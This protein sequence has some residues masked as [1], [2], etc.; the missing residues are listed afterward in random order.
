MALEAKLVEVGSE[1][2]EFGI[3][4]NELYLPGPHP[5]NQYLYGSMLDVKY[6]ED[7][8]LEKRLVDIQTRAPIA[9]GQCTEFLISAPWKHC[10]EL[11]IK[12][13]T[14]RKRKIAKDF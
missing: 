7:G 5:V 2:E 10:C 12:R 9:K 11:S 14:S 1:M 4:F 13:H 8:V 6:L 3:P